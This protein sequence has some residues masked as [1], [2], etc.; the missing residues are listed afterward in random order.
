MRHAS[1]LGCRF[2]S[3]SQ[4]IRG[5]AILAIEDGTE[6][7]TRVLLETVPIDH[8]AT[9]SYT[10][11]KTRPRRPRNRPDRPAGSSERAG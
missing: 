7:I 10:A 4:L 3:L 11:A 1:T 9:L 2:G 5:A 8:A 6:R